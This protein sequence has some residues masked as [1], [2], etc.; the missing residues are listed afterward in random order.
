MFS[1]EDFNIYS[2]TDSL[3]P[4]NKASNLFHQKMY[5]P[6]LCASLH[7]WSPCNIQF[8]FFPLAP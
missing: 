6:A 7:L 4:E 2:F 3:S 8:N 5:N 1:F